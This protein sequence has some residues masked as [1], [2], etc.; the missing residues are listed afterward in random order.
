[1]MK[2]SDMEITQSLSQHT[3]EFRH[4][5]DHLGAGRKSQSQFQPNY[6]DE[7]ISHPIVINSHHTMTQP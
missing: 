3:R 7:D 2:T 1:M 6:D 4:T 5:Y